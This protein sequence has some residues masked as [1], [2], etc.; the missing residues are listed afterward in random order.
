LSKTKNK[1]M[2]SVWGSLKEFGKKCLRVLRV[3][4]KPTPEEFKRASKI[5]AIGILIIGF[6]GFL[7]SI[8]FIIF[9]LK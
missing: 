9:K 3:A 8:A 1:K 5:S 6:I 7:I 2:L 4:R